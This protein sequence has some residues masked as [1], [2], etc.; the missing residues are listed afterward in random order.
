MRPHS[1]IRGSVPQRRHAIDT[2]DTMWR[3]ASAIRTP[4]NEFEA[5]SP[6]RLK[7]TGRP[8][9]SG[10]SSQLE[11][12]LALSLNFSSRLAL[13]SHTARRTTRRRERGAGLP[14]Q[15]GLPLILGSAANEPRQR[16][17][18]YLARQRENPFNPLPNPPT[19]NPDHRTPN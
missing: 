8:Q 9:A 4:S 3:R 5:E 11:L 14:I 1:S 7:P 15:G 16:M 10:H 17:W 12:T 6:S 18:S 2:R 19:P 13:R